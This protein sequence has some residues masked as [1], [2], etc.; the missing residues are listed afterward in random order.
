MHLLAKTRRHTEFV[1][2]CED[3]YSPSEL[4]SLQLLVHI[5]YFSLILHFYRTG[6]SCNRFVALSA[7]WRSAFRATGPLHRHAAFSNRKLANMSAHD[8]SPLTPWLLAHRV[9]VLAVVPMPAMSRDSATSTYHGL[10]DSRKLFCRDW[11]I[12]LFLKHSQRFFC[13]FKQSVRILE[14]V[15]TQLLRS[16]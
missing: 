2:L 1:R 3:L 13:S 10:F 14:A 12:P 7:H 5:H 4:N 11:F 6:Y 15:C 9:S 8:A 16:F